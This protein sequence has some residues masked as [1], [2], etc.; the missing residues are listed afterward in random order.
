[1][2]EHSIPALLAA[3]DVAAVPGPPSGYRVDGPEPAWRVTPPDEEAV[4]RILA[5]A[6][7][8]RAAVVP[9]GSGTRDR[10]GNPLDRADIVLE[11]TALD[12]VVEYNPADLTVTVQAGM[13]LA[14]LQR[15]LGEE[16]QW[17]SVDPPGAE[18]M[19]VGGW[20]ASAAAG[21][22]RL[23]YGAPRD[24]VLGLRVVLT[25]GHVIRTGGRV[26]KNVAGYDLTRLFTGSMGTLGVITEV[27]MKVRPVPEAR[28]TLAYGFG[29]PE[30]ARR[31]ARA[32]VQSELLP[33]ALEV[34]CPGAAE[35][36]RA[37]GPWAAAVLL[38]E[39]RAAIAYQ[40][41]RLHALAREA[42]ARHDHR[43]DDGEA[44]AFW[45]RLSRL[46]EEAAVAARVQVPPA[47]AVDVLARATTLVHSLGLPEALALQGTAGA[48]TGTV[49]L[50]LSGT[51]TEETLGPLAAWANALAAAA[52]EHEGSLVVEA[53]PAGLKSRI[54]VWGP[55]GPAHGL[56]VGIK[57]RFDPERVLNP[58]R[59]VGGI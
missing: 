32:V 13:R 14:E 2:P 45:K 19:T 11:T 54:Q 36:V 50:L 17:L 59:F 48:G 58:G 38:E 33:A 6:R 44:A 55:P 28:R 4:C 46:W 10:A 23:A 31:F 15:V 34:F 47:A 18:R 51:V 16:G 29:E 24:L 30:A 5:L 25:A 8:N 49:R 43:T 53:A 27:S 9:R 42:G 7:A 40:T 3:A 37:P 26:V 22:R 12:R 57:E 56:M 1:M 39:T 35:A 20:V 41:E 21:P 52:R